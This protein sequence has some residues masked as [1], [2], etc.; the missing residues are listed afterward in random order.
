MTPLENEPQTNTTPARAVYFAH[1]CVRTHERTYVRTRAWNASA[2]SVRRMLRG[3]LIGGLPKGNYGRAASKEKLQKSRAKAASPG[4]EI[5]ASVLRAIKI[6]IGRNRLANALITPVFT[7]LRRSLLDEITS[8]VLTLS[9]C[10]VPL[11]ISNEC[12]EVETRMHAARDERRE[13]VP[14]FIT[15]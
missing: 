13:R 1:P 14:R 3:R 4:K 11:E 7:H 6:E 9:F 10:K 5:I 15:S 2:N 12:I 8:R